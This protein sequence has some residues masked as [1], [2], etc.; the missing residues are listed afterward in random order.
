MR[1]LGGSIW[2]DRIIT[3]SAAAAV[4]GAKLRL[5]DSGFGG[6]CRYYKTKSVQWH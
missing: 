3:A 2:P 5:L 4:T 6:N 1:G